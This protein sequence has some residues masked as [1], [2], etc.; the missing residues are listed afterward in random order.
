M[1]SQHSLL[2]DEHQ[3]LIRLGS[4]RLVLSELPVLLVACLGGVACLGWWWLCMCWWPG[5]SVSVGLSGPSIPSLSVASGRH[6]VAANSAPPLS[7]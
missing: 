3:N 7:G 1:M 5:P 4:P 2:G 6:S